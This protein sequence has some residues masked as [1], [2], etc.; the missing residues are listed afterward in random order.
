MLR[1][2]FQHSLEIFVY[3]TANPMC[4][5]SKIHILAVIKINVVL[6]EHIIQTL[7]KVLQ[8]EKN[9]S[10]PSLH[11]NLYLIDV[12]THLQKD[13]EALLHTANTKDRCPVFMI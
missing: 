6:V 1:L 2:T 7:I 4:L 5:Q 12:S 11:A 13:F 3:S 8:V 9:N 10:T